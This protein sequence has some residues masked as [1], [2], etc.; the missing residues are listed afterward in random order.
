RFRVGGRVRARGLG[1]SGCGGGA[2]LLLLR[3]LR[4]GLDLLLVVGRD[5]LGEEP[6]Q[7][8]GEQQHPDRAEDQRAPV[9]RLAAVPARALAAALGVALLDALR[10]RGG[11]DADALL[12]RG[13]LGGLRR[14]RLGRRLRGG[15]GGGRRRLG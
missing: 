9:L 3:G 15:L 1:R 4:G 2:L 13:L 10:G 12:R 11:G 5:L 14:G 6:V 7:A 8:D